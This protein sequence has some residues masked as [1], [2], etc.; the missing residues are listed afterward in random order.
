M[1]VLYLSLLY[2]KQCFTF[3]FRLNLTSQAN[4]RMELSVMASTTKKSEE[5]FHALLF[6]FFFLLF[7]F[8]CVC[9]Y[10]YLCAHVCMRVTPTKISN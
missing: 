9:V 10:V 6:F 2:Y 5:I 3:V 1:V 7:F 4:D 8:V